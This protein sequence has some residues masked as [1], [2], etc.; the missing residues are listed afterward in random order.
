IAPYFQDIVMNEL[1][2]K[3]KL[4]EETIETDGLRVYTSL[5]PNLQK[6]AEEEVQGHIHK[7]S[8]IQVGFVAMEPKT[9]HVKAL[10][11]GRNYEES[12]FNRVTQAFRQPGSTFKP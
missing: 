5:D 12:P 2:S 10:V 8:E 6:L 1:V 3:L 7:D 9:G 11:G 4:D